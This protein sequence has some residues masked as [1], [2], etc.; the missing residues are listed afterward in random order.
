MII[1]FIL[2]IAFFVLFKFVLF[3]P[4]DVV[5]SSEADGSKMYRN[6]TYELHVPVD[7]STSLLPFVNMITSGNSTKSREI[8]VKSLFDLEHKMCI[9]QSFSYSYKIACIIINTIYDLNLSMFGE[10]DLSMIE[11]CRTS[12]IDTMRDYF[13]IVADNKFVSR[14]CDLLDIITSED[15]ESFVSIKRECQSFVQLYSIYFSYISIHEIDN[16]LLYYLGI[17]NSQ[18]ETFR[19]FNDLVSSY[20]TINT[21]RMTTY[22][23]M[24]ISM[25]SYLT[26]HSP[27][28][29]IDLEHLYRTETQSSCY[30]ACIYTLS[31]SKAFHI[32]KIKGIKYCVHRDNTHDQTFI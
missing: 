26:K 22:H 17:A 5:G 9:S 14:L 24:I 21:T 27:V 8:I 12:A 10:S 11:S 19:S 28:P 32:E 25:R 4:K 18:G 20:L 13:Y 23:K 7:K 6:G 15:D 2:L 30:D 31:H 1:L 16:E 3:N 29:I